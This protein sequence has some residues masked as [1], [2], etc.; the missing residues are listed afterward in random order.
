MLHNNDI[1]TQ[2]AEHMETVTL[3]DRP[4]LLKIIKAVDPKFRKHRAFLHVRNEVSMHGTFWDE[5]S[6]SSYFLVNTA[7]GSVTAMPHHAP[8][9]FGGPRETPTYKLAPGQAMVEMGV[10]CGRPTTPG[11][12]LPTA[13]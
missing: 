13:E 8:P 1:A 11:I 5:G 9:Q 6:R 7:T 4:D 10:F 12:Y 3:K 2:K